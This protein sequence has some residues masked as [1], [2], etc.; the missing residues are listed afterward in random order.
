MLCMAIFIKRRLQPTFYFFRAL[1]ASID[2][3]ADKNLLCKVEKPSLAARNT[4]LAV[5]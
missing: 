1:V 4:A 2:E 5:L 3:L